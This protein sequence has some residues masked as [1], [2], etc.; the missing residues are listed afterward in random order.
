MISWLTG[1]LGAPLLAQVGIG[2]A[3]AL[4]AAIVALGFT[5]RAW[6]AAKADLAAEIERCNTDKAL[7][8]ASAEEIVRKATQ[9]AAD[10]RIRQLEAERDRE[11]AAVASEREKRLQAERAANERGQQLQELAEEAFDEDDIPDSDA[12]L[13][14]FVTSRALRCVLDAGA[15][16]GEAGAG[17]GGSSALCS[18]PEG[19]DGLHPGFSNVTYLDALRYWGGDRDVAT[20]LNGRLAAIE[21]L[22]GELVDGNT[23]I[24]E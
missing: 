20:R 6:I 12:C 2:L 14:A 15:N 3:V 5:G 23:D 9:E 4:F 10:R 21:K 16:R 8:I 22:S 24:T 13:N 1:R 11:V 19:A 18:N 7:A 17:G